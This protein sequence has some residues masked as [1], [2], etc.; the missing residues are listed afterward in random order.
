MTE[1]QQAKFEGWAIV[2]VFGH[3]RYVGHVT[4]EAFGA[5]VMFRVDVPALEPRQRV[6][7]SPEYLGNQYVPAGTTVNEGAVPG[8]TKLFGVGAIYGI[9]PCTQ[10]AAMKAVDEMHRRP[11]MKISVPEG[12]ALP[13]PRLDDDFDDRD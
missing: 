11:L 9:T 2:E 1:T 10:D 7:K 3:Q 12:L 13:A 5:A 6:T 4:T 8:Y